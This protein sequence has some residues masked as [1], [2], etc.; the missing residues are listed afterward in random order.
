MEQEALLQNNPLLDRSIRNR[1]PY[2]D[3]LNHV[4]VELLKRT[5]NNPDEQVL[6]GIQLSINGIAAGL[7]NSGLVALADHV[8]P[9][10]AV[11]LAVD[12]T[13]GGADDLVQARAGMG[14]GDQQ[15]TVAGAP[16][17]GRR[18]VGL[19]CRHGFQRQRDSFLAQVAGDTAGRRRA[20]VAHQRA[21][22]AAQ[23]AGLLGEI[24]QG[25]HGDHGLAPARVR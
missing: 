23:V 8:E 22:I 21:R 7:R 20:H 16:A 15:E 24:Q 6:R 10:A 25:L 1:F 17:L 2:L 14:K 19:T 18:R 9:G 12:R 5:A 4:Q 3:P 11:G 13:H